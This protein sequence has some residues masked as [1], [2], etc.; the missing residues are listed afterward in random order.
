M[1]GFAI[2]IILSFFVM[3]LF[4]YDAMDWRGA[5]S[6]RMT[7]NDKGFGAGHKKNDKEMT[8]GLGGGVT[9][10]G[11]KKTTN[12]LQNDSKV[13]KN[14]KTWLQKWLKND[15]ASRIVPIPARPPLPFWSH[16]GIIFR[17]FG[18]FLSFS[19]HFV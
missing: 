18:V 10:N 8:R 11:W 6:P 15:N 14:D 12:L 9:K 17:H 4:L 5:K 7:K 16:F 1:G 3:C 13:T 2:V 19:N